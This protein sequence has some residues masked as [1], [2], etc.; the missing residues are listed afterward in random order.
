[1]IRKEKIS[2]HYGVNNKK[3]TIQSDI[4][5]EYYNEEDIEKMMSE[6]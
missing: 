5:Y 2:K 3:E 4:D 6:N 1:M